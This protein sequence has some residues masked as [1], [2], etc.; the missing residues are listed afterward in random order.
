MPLLDL[1][2]DCPD[3][4]FP[5]AAG[6][7]CLPVKCKSDHWF[8]NPL[9]KCQECEGDHSFPDSNGWSCNKVDCEPDQLL[10][11]QGECTDACDEFE[12]TDLEGK[13]CEKAERAMEEA[14]ATAPDWSHYSRTHERTKDV[15]RYWTSKT[16]GGGPLTGDLRTE[17]VDKIQ[18]PLSELMSMTSTYGIYSITKVIVASGRPY[19]RDITILSTKKADTT[20]LKEYAADTRAKCCYTMDGA[21][22][23]EQY[24]T[25]FARIDMYMDTELNGAR[26][27]FLEIVYEGQI[28]EGVPYGFGRKIDGRASQSF[29]GYFKDWYNVVDE[30]SLGLYFEYFEL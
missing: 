23:I 5:D 14:L 26:P 13:K 21:K 30:P 25:G 15:K 20:K 4:N 27:Q 24:L 28:L 18:T 9:G 3:W 16:L 22:G 8:V 7:K 2:H 1:C 29:I 19:Y 10:S 6:K 12:Y 11:L 17:A